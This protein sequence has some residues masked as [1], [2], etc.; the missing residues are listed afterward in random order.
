MNNN[1][2]DI[3]SLKEKAN[4]FTVLYVE[5]E[6]LLRKNIHQFL[7]KIFLHVDTAIDG[8]DA[9]SKYQEKK[10]DIVI[11]DILMPNMNG[12]EFIKQIREVN[13]N[14]E[15]IVLSA[16]TDSYYFTEAIQL[17]VTGYIIKPI[18][19]IQT[20][21]VLYQ[22]IKKL[23][24]FRENEIYKN[25]LESMVENR[26]RKV[27]EL[28]EQLVDNY[29][30]VIHSFVKLIERRDTYTGGHSERVAKYSQDIAK[31]M[32]LSQEDCDKIYKAGILH[33]IG[34]IA[35]PDSILLKPSNLTKQEYSLIQDH[36]EIGYEILSENPMY[37]DIADTIR[38]HHERC[39]GSG[40]PQGLKDKQIP[41]H[42]KIMAVADTFD[43][44]TSNRIYKRKKSVK[45]AIDELTKLSGITYDEDVVKSAIDVFKHVN[46]SDSIDQ[47]PKSYIDDERFAYFYKD[48]LTR[49]Y[50]SQYLDF[51][52][53]K[54][55]T[56]MT[57]KCINVLYLKNFTQYNKK[58]GWNK[59][60]TLLKE[61][62]SYLLCEF[63]NFKIFR[64]FGDDFVLIHNLHVDIDIDKIN[65]ISLLKNNNLFCE[66]K[67]MSLKDSKITN[68]IELQE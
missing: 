4:Q 65:N 27:F 22:S 57:F 29:E 15:I 56:D 54:N 52:L 53:Q 60:D 12:I 10:H 6:E 25:Q 49:T 47:T 13:K 23:T 68:Y 19:F 2:I 24:A 33:D 31:Q 51:I 61:F 55:L 48:S 43:A 21:D 9:W 32:G 41:L 63:E 30:H 50:N 16:H 5:D 45:D 18:D 66:L 7:N 40:Y 58:H 26:T 44:M 17:S 64:I 11:T 1:T 59:G 14:Q 46:L 34:K 20:L 36:A 38:A 28:K 62:A 39:D 3:K 67:H 8:K 37:K 42:S 35:I